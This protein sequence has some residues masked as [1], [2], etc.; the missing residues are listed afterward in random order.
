MAG[1]RVAQKLY[2]ADGLDN[3][4]H[5]YYIGLNPIETRNGSDQV[6]TH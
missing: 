4:I 1:R 6:T 2:T 5:T 3:V